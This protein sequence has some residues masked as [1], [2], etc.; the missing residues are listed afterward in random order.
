MIELSVGETR[1]R[2]KIGDFL[3]GKSW[4]ER[5]GENRAQDIKNTLS[6]SQ[7][8]KHKKNREKHSNNCRI[9]QKKRWKNS[10]YYKTQRAAI[11]NVFSSDKYR[12]ERSKLQK[13]KW[14]E[15]EYRA[16]AIE[17]RKKFIVPFKDTSI[18]VR[19]QNYL[20]LLHIEFIT[21]YYVSDIDDSYRCDIFIPTQDGIAKKTV[22]ECDG[23][24]WHFCPI[25][26]INKKASDWQT[27]QI[28][29]DK[30]RTKEL[31]AKG[32]RV[33][34]LWEHYIR[35]MELKDLKNMLINTK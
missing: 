32:F 2:K 29:R 22:I 19:I 17:S 3:R 31:M 23:C 30:N 12:K 27:V 4:E 5:Y 10:E 33:I 1:R 15:P 16:A 28:K 14:E 6:K 26:N 7:K 35:K 13:E 34:R 18:E 21:H 8:G 11:N 9:A 20:K 25:C 24:Y